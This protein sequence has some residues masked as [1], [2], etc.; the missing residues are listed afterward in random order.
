[1]EVMDFFIKQLKRR[2]VQMFGTL[3]LMIFVIC[4]A[5]NF[6]SLIL[7]TIIFTYIGHAGINFLR[8]WLHLNQ[9]IGT[10]VFYILLISFIVFMISISASELYAQLKGIP[11]LVEKTIA[12]SP[13][14]SKQI[15]T[16]VTSFTKNTEAVKNSQSLAVSGLTK[17]E[18]VGRSI[19]HV[20]LALFLSLIYNLTFN[21]LIEFGHS[22][23]K[24]EYSKFFKYVFYLSQK[25]I[26]I[27]GTV[28][29]TQL[30][31]CSINTCLMTIGLWIIG[32]PK[33]LVLAIIVFAL[34][35]VPVAG[36]IIS[37][38]PLSV[39]ALSA[40]GLIPMLEVWVLVLIV[41]LFESYFLHPR[42][43]AGATD[44]PI[45]TTFITLIISGELFG[46]WG[47]IV[48]IPLVAFFLDLFD[49]QLPHHRQKTL[50]DTIEEEI[51]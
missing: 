45:F 41:H 48:G 44:L 17:L 8:K 31:I 9:A 50:K 23:M 43:M 10:I 6:L 3:V 1:M 22:F 35:L 24:S 39:I 7:L 38:F 16:L 49:V 5:K 29:E 37:L 42:L 25:F 47:L 2:E 15:D 51:E 28:V 32:V 33:L 36:V 18:H 46:P 40:G 21:H 26:T 27:L 12:N 13:A 4:M 20:I 30:L 34:G 11:N 14:L 19:E